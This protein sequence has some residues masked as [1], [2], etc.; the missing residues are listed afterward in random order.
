MA[1]KCEKSAGSR[2]LTPLANFAIG[3]FQQNVAVMRRSRPPCDQLATESAANKVAPMRE[4]DKAIVQLVKQCMSRF[5]TTMNKQHQ[6]VAKGQPAPTLAPPEVATAQVSVP[7]RLLPQGAPIQWGPATADP[8]PAPVPQNALAA[9]NQPQ[10]H[11]QVIQGAVPGEAQVV[12]VVV[13]GQLQPQVQGQ[14]V[15]IV[16]A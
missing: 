15:P 13:P 10:A 3:E 5:T 12:P 16:P 7:S 2:N 6:D 11:G 14:V 4:A 1:A 8:N 9:I